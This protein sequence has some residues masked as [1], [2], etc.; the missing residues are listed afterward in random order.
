MCFVSN[1]ILEDVALGTSLCWDVT[2]SKPKKQA[3]GIFLRFLPFFLRQNFDIH[4]EEKD[5]VLGDVKP[6]MGDRKQVW[7]KVL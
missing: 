7:H 1:R 5:N 6:G 2:E 3:D 4:R